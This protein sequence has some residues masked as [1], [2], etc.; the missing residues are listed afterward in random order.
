MYE[1]R[2][3]AGKAK[4]MSRKA[5]SHPEPSNTLLLAHETVYVGIDIGKRAHVAGFL[6]QTLLTRHL[7]FEHCPALSFE[8]SREGF[9]LLVERMQAFVPLT[10]IQVLLEVTGHYHRALMQYLQ[11]LNIPV[12]IIHVQ[13]R[14]EG[15][16]K[17]DK[18]DA[19]GL[20]NHLYNQMEK[21]IQVDDP[22][23]A[24]RKL[25][26]PTEAAAQLRGMV[27]HHGELVVESTQRK[28]RLTSIC[29]ELFPE[30]THLLR[31]PNL[32]TALAL[33]ARFPTP[34]LL[35]VATFAELREARGRTCS[36][37]DAKLRE[38]QH[39]AA[40]SVG[41][42]DPARVNGLVFEQ[43]QLIAE[44]K[45]LGVHLQELEQEI[46]QVVEGSREGK[47]LTS[48]PGI[49]PQA[50]AALISTIGTIANFEHPAQ[51]KSY[52][53]WVPKIA[54]S[55]SSLDWSRLTSRGVRQMRQTMYLIV[56]RA[57]QWDA[58]WKEVYER[59]VGRKCHVDERTRR[60]VGREKVIGRLAG[61]MTSIIFVL[62]K[63]D[64]ELL[65][66]L[67]PGATPPEPQ[68]YDRELHRKHRMGGYQPSRSEGKSSGEIQLA[69]S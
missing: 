12:Y 39:L 35:A 25:A 65:A 22:L 23:Q 20:A 55:G 31:N 27:Q 7:R 56:W 45:L 2:T 28:N 67:A 64:Q 15:L 54:Q 36:V 32:P 13:K 37:S 60:L 8:N 18:R 3:D 16:L 17:S 11:D 63:K 47:I 30:L 46:V 68:L 58:D 10:Q 44:L 1:T 53:G 50:A 66:H 24:V 57:I 48:I 34:S 40:Q 43:K 42:R 21:G 38:L 59:L 41:V 6:S 51:L 33:R 26:P 61:Q 5:T 52:F 29:D 49:G 19:L 9:R 4:L 69:P 62:L 14:R